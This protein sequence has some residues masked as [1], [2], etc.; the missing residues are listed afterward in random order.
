[1]LIDGLMT[2]DNE[3]V[4]GFIVA[5]ED[6]RF[7]PATAVIRGGKLEVSAPAGFRAGS[8]ALCYCNFFRVNLYNKAG[9]RYSFPHRYRGSR[10]RMPVGLPIRKWYVFRK[11]I[12]WTMGS[13][14]SL[15]MRRV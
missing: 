8:C 10:I 12:S 7:Y 2:P 6:R 5:G 14:C 13:V 4:K 11:P 15:D 3:P 1:M 9:F